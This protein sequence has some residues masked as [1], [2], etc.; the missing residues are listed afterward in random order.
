[1]ETYCPWINKD[2]KKLMQT[3]DKLKKVAVKRKSQV[4]MDAYK[5]VRNK[6]NVLN[7]KLKRQYYTAK[8]VACQGKMKES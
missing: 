5:Q 4:L 7:I 8:I 6:V 3:R 2:L 1:M